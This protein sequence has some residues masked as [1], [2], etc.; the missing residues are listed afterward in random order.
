MTL[1]RRR[2]VDRRRRRTVFRFPDRRTGFDR[3]RPGGLLAWYRDRPALIAVALATIVALNIADYALT[4]RALERG[5]REANP[6]MATL[7]AHDPTVALAFKLFTAVAV[8]LV[9]WQ[10][11]RYR[12]ILGV[13]LLAVGGFGLLVV[14]QIGVVAA[15]S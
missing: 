9:I 13:S 2:E 1:E 4:L 15:L 14:Y 11:R 12:K 3:R 5:A 10:L 6:I 8:V 7:F